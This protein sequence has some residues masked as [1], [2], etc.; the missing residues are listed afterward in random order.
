MSAKTEHK[1]V[2]GV[3]IFGLLVLLL[4]GGLFLIS[5]FADEGLLDYHNY[6]FE[7]AVSPQGSGEIQDFQIAYDFVNEEG[8]ILF[9][10][11]DTNGVDAMVFHFPED[12][13]VTGFF[14][15]NTREEANERTI[16]YVQ[17]SDY[18]Q[19]SGLTSYNPVQLVFSVESISKENKRGRTYVRLTFVG[20][21]YPNANFRFLGQGNVKPRRYTE[22]GSF[23]KF[24]LGEKYICIQEPCYQPHEGESLEFF[25]LENWLAVRPVKTGPE[26]QT[27]DYERFSLNYNKKNNKLLAALRSISYFFLALGIIPSIELLFYTLYKRK[28]KTRK[29]K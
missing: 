16:N 6:E 29:K 1:V 11:V 8:T 9:S 21:L 7:A 17:G 19:N 18:M 27:L 2:M 12:I 10:L 13:S 4:G 26:W 24:N 15:N 5:L 3:R 25:R 28:R 14:W 23:F 20:K 22:Q